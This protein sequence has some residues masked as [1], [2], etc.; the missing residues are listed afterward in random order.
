MERITGA[1]PVL[2]TPFTSDGTHVD[3]EDLRAVVE[4]VIRDGASGLVVF[5]FATEF[6][7]LSDGER[8]WMVKVVIETAAG[9]I[10]VIPSVTD[11]T[12]AEAI[13]SAGEYV[14]A[15]ADAV[16]VLPRFSE[17]VVGTLKAVAQQMPED[18]PLF[19]QIEPEA[20]GI[21]VPVEDIVRLD[22]AIP[23]PLAIKAEPKMPA[24]QFI[25]AVHRGSEGRISLYT[26]NQGIVMYEALD[27]G[28]V[29]VMPGCS[30]V[31][32]YARIVREFLQGA[33]DRAFDLYNRLVPYLNVFHGP[34]ELQ[35]EKR[36][37]V[38]R[39][40]FKTDYCRSGADSDESVDAYT[41]A[42]L[43]KYYGYLKEQFP[44]QVT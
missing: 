27:R 42:Y 7:T 37:L 17:E 16:M 1:L 4:A 11:T 20:T 43:W 15:G 44:Q 31:G 8:D 9:R 10:P 30:M 19:V 39:G 25:A 22:E 35:F 2:E 24:G 14:S 18:A 23:N 12:A 34:H 21:P 40:I 6:A 36:I 26:G 41:E 5:G 29:G 38:K 13:A 33:K 28:A 3:E 32:V